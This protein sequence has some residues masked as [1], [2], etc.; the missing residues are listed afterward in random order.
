MA[1]RT[2]APAVDRLRCARAGV[3]SGLVHLGAGHGLQMS[4]V[5]GERVHV[6]AAV[7]HGRHGL[8]RVHSMMC[9]AQA[10]PTAAR[11][12][13]NRAQTVGSRQRRNLGGRGDL[14]LYVH[15][16]RRATTEQ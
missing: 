15:C 6:G 14:R 8:Q 3:H 2:P 11:R 7:R 10:Q 13:R 1:I 16:C 5:F 12:I 4:D 9:S